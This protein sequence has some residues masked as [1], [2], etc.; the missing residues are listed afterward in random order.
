MSASL[1]TNRWFLPLRVTINISFTF[2]LSDDPERFLQL[3]SPLL[4]NIRY[5][6]IIPRVRVGYEM[7]LR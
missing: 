3:G 1:N 2:T 4:V 7:V 6:T 5:L